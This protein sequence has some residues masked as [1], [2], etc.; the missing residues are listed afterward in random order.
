MPAWRDARQAVNAGPAEEVQEHRFGI[1]IGMMGGRDVR[2]PQRV[3]AVRKEIVPGSPCGV[4]NRAFFRFGK[5]RHIGVSGN[6]RKSEPQGGFTDEGAVAVGFSS[7]EMMI[8]VCDSQSTAETGLQF[9]ERIEE[10][11]GIDPAAH[12]EKHRIARL[13]EAG[14]ADKRLKRVQ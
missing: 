8:E 7:A 14:L 9:Y 12:G 4:L 10:H 5:R 3:P 11:H 6:E 2:E 1:V 13:D